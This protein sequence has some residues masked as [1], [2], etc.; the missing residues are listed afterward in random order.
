[1][2]KRRETAV[3]EVVFSRDREKAVARENAILRDMFDSLR[4]LEDFNQD[5]YNLWLILQELNTRGVKPNAK[6]YPAK[7]SD[8]NTLFTAYVILFVLKKKIFVFHVFLKF[9]PCFLNKSLL[10]SLQICKHLM[11]FML[12]LQHIG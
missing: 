5:H 4:N 8:Q 10:K 1:M 6:L 2:Q 3:S 12:A 7:D 9:V 11:I